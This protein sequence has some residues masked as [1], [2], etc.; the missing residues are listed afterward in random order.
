MRSLPVVLLH[1]LGQHGS[2]ELFI[3]HYDVV[4]ALAAQG[5]DHSFSDRVG[6]WRVD[7]RGESVDADAL[8]ALSEVASVDSVTISE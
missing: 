5:A 4:E 6:L 8:G 7:Q 2:Q 1:E 3:Q